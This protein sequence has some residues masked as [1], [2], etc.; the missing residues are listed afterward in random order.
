MKIFSFC[1][2]LCLGFA[3]LYAQDFQIPKDYNFDE[4][5]GI[6]KYEKDILNCINWLDNTPYNE[7]VDK[8]KE[9]YTF[10][11]MWISKT[12]DISI[13]INPNVVQFTDKNPDL[14]ITFMGGWTRLQMEDPKTKKNY[15]LG[16]IAG[17]KNVIRFYQKNKSAL[18]EDPG[19]EKLTQLQVKGGLE[20]W[21]EEQM[22]K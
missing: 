12:S 6:K 17:L 16:N 8:R 18:T 7:Q 1:F 19:I 14:M 13:E 9:A 3:N 15:L 21:V 5:G 2:L 22:A 10:L 11:V 4:P 20:K